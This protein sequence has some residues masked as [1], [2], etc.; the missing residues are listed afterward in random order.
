MEGVDDLW[1]DGGGGGGLSL[2]GERVREQRGESPAATATSAPALHQLAEALHDVGRAI[3]LVDDLTGQVLH[4]ALLVPVLAALAPALPPQRR[5]RAGAGA[6]VLHVALEASEG[7]RALA[8]AHLLAGGLGAGA[9][10]GAALGDA[11]RERDPQ[12]VQG[13]AALRRGLLHAAG[14]VWEVGAVEISPLLVLRDA[15]PIVLPGDDGR[16]TAFHGRAGTERSLHPV[17]LGPAGRERG[18]NR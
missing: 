16:V 10:R 1:V 7:G 3:R 11:L 8:A 15:A 4:V 9:G 18:K 5:G 12:A 13:S 17:R 2:L 14:R 6:A